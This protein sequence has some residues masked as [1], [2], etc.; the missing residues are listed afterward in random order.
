MENQGDSK[1]KAVMYNTTPPDSPPVFSENSGGSAPNG[2]DPSMNTLQGSAPPSFRGPDGRNLLNTTLAFNSHPDEPD[3]DR[4]LTPFRIVLGDIRIRLKRGETNLTLSGYILEDIIFDI[5]SPDRES[6]SV[7]AM[8]HDFENHLMENGIG[9]HSNVTT[10]VECPIDPGNGE[11]PSPHPH[12]ALHNFTS[13]PIGYETGGPS[14]YWFPN[15]P[16][17]TADTPR[18]LL[19]RP[20]IMNE[21][22]YHQPTGSETYE[23][24]AYG[25]HRT[26]N[27]RSLMYQP[28]TVAPELSRVVEDETL[29]YREE[30]EYI[31]QPVSWEDPQPE[32]W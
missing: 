4:I 21:F 28:R 18:G 23:G 31:E 12:L 32:F 27:E 14:N 1:G 22:E 19:H 25:S 6:P 15:V 17:N 30:F 7:R 29:E 9:L 8:I 16:N 20:H 24:P 11:M 13:S 26:L 5:E 2:S 10:P 3:P